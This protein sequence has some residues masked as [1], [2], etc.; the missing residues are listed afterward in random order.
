MALPATLGGSPRGWLL[1]EL[2]IIIQSS[3]G[4]LQFKIDQLRLV[5][6]QTD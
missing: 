1:C 5:M 2:P 4:L 6:V 3:K